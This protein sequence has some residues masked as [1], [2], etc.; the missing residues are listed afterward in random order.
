MA[1][2]QDALDPTRAVAARVRELREKR[3]L[4][5]AQLAAAMTGAGIK[6]DRSTV[7]KLETGRRENVSVAELLALAAVLEVAPVHLL[8][9]LED[10]QPY[11]VT[12]GRVEPARRVRAWVSGGSPLAGIDPRA[13]WSE[14]PKEEWELVAPSREGD[15][16][17]QVRALREE[18][19][20]LRKE[21][22]E[23][24]H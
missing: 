3:R 8:I 7:A 20:R 23:F 12:P 14:V 9:P 22:E 21:L 17:G 15:E 18:M 11:E 19:R 6:W 1:H 2:D 24:E 10:D 5:A 13:Y 16:A 4:T